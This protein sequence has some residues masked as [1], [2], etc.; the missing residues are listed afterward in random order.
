MDIT[1]GMVAISVVSMSVA[2]L[3]Q[4]W[5]MKKSGGKNNGHLTLIEADKRYTEIKLCQQIHKN[6]DEKLTCIPEI[7]DT[8]A[9]LETKVDILISQK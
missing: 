5:D 1:E 2:V 8:V 9:R 7:K 3:K 6:T 4:S